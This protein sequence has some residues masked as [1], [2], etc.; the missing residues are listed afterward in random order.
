MSGLDLLRRFSVFDIPKVITQSSKG[1]NAYLIMELIE[2]ASK[3]VV[4]WQELG[5]KLAELHR[6]SITKFGLDEDNFIGSLP[7]KNKFEDDWSTFFTNQRIMPMIKMASDNS[8]LQKGERNTLESALS[9][10]TELMP[11]E[12][13]SLLHGDLW[14][15]NLMT[16]ANG[17][18]CLIDPAVYYGHRE[19]DI[20][21]SHLFGGFSPDFYHSYQEAYPMESGFN[22]RIDLY[23]LYPLLVHLNLFGR[24]YIGQ[25]NSITGQF[26]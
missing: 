2:P 22:Q 23:N 15:G 24:S 13:P 10:I 18:P 12:A 1:G 20:A 8:L 19:M 9:K 4:Y 26:T 11:K 25:I 14:S 16:S 5:I 17:E 3:S 21:F 6:N 7:Q